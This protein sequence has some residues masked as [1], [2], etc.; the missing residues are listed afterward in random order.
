MQKSVEVLCPLKLTLFLNYQGIDKQTN[1]KK[2]NI[3]NQTIDIYDKLVITEFKRKYDGINIECNDYKEEFYKTCKLFF[4]YTNI[5]IN[6]LLLEIEIANQDLTCLGS[7]DSI[8]AGILLGLDRYYQT[9]LTKRELVFLALNLGGWVPYFLVSGYAKINNNQIDVLKDNKFQNY[10]LINTKEN[11]S[12]N[13]ILEKLKDLNVSL[14]SYNEAGLYNDFTKIMPDEIIRL[15]NF[16]N[17]FSS[18]NHSLSDLGPIYFIGYDN[19][20]F[21]YHIKMLLKKEFPNYSFYSSKN[22]TGHKIIT[23]YLNYY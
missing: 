4:D 17:N 6:S 23:R 11:Y 19:K 3:I 12:N 21:P 18:I 16:L 9:N 10:L 5:K 8:M 1:L 20:S 7:K 2:L 14:K 22:S 15:R 13:F